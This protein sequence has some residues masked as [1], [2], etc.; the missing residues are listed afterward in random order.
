MHELANKAV[1][2]DDDA[3]GQLVDLANQTG[4]QKQGAPIMGGGGAV[5][6]YNEALSKGQQ[7]AKDY[8]VWELARIHGVT[9]G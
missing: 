1:S 7:L 2:G 4:P 5:N 6:V 3:L 9:G 8:A